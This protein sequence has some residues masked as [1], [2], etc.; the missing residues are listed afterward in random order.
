M[1][2]SSLAHS[3]IVIPTQDSMEAVSSVLSADYQYKF[4]SEPSDDLKCL[5]CLEVAEDPWQHSKCGKLFCNKC[6]DDYGRQK[7]C[8]NCRMTCPQYFEDSRSELVF[9]VFSLN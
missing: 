4:I 9:L 3:W 1:S 5:V 6:L 2:V 7:P 8:P